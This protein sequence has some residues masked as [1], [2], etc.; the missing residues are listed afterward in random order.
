MIAAGLSNLLDTARREKS[1]GVV[2][3]MVATIPEGTLPD[4][5]EIARVLLAKGYTVG[6]IAEH[7]DAVVEA[8]KESTR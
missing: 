8:M 4:D 3:A 5:A 6:M 2:A 7:L 1:A